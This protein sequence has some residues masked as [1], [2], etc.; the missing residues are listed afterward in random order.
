M[1]SPQTRTLI[2]VAS[3]LL[4]VAVGCNDTSTGPAA[5]QGPKTA[6]SVSPKSLDFGT[7]CV[8]ES[9]TKSF[10]IYAPASNTAPAAGTVGTADAVYS[11]TAGGGDYSLDPGDSL[12]VSVKF[13]P[14]LG[15]HSGFSS[16]VSTG[17]PVVS[18]WGVGSEYAYVKLTPTSLTKTQLETNYDPFRSPTLALTGVSFSNPSWDGCGS[19]W[20]VD[21]NPV[22]ESKIEIRSLSVPAGVK[23]L[24]VTLHMDASNSCAQLLI[25]I[26][27]AETVK[28]SLPT[29]CVTKSY[30]ITW[31]SSSAGKHTIGIGTDQQGVTCFSDIALDSIKLTFEGYCAP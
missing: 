4:L 25:E 28:S 10:K 3:V 1:K 23:S 30:R 16:G 2:G 18:L 20:I 29:S 24:L 6:V 14:N 26:D 22:T 9:M 13:A 12:E 7:V 19:A 17:G 21:G 8:G 15:F 5:P 11:V 27:G 31:P